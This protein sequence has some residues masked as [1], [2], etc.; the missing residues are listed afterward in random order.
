MVPYDI[1][2]KERVVD[3]DLDGTATVDMGAF[4]H[5]PYGIYLPVIME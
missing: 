4:E 1:E 5:Y 2:Y 3:G